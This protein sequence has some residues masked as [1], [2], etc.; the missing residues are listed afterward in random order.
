VGLVEASLKIT[1]DYT[2][3]SKPDQVRIVNLLI[4]LMNRSGTKVALDFITA[5]LQ[6]EKL[7]EKL[8]NDPIFV[9]H[10]G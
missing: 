10:L 9:N 1:M 3:V 8:T 7:R 6:L 4:T 2:K 5:N